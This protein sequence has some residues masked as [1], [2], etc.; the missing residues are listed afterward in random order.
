MVS[1]FEQLLIQDL[2]TKISG[3]HVIQIEAIT[4]NT[5]SVVNSDNF[6]LVANAIKSSCSKSAHNYVQG[7]T[8]GAPKSDLL[9]KAEILVSKGNDLIAFIIIKDTDGLV[10]FSE[11][12]SIKGKNKSS[13]LPNLLLTS[14]GSIQP[15]LEYS[16]LTNQGMDTVQTNF[17]GTV[18]CY[19]ITGSQYALGR[20]DLTFG[21]SIALMNTIP[22][23]VNVNT[24]APTIYNLMT[25]INSEL[26]IKEFRLFKINSNL[27]WHT[28]IMTDMTQLNFG[29]YNFSSGLGL[30]ISRNFSL[31]TGIELCNRS[32]VPWA[33]K[34]LGLNAFDRFYFG[35]GLG[36]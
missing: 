6:F 11:L 24:Q 30:Y 28:S 7:V 15:N 10:R 18:L 9:L 1:K 8:N 16:S 31:R 3:I 36:F 27:S 32:L 20:R 34:P 19:Q 26:L 4:A 22:I 23:N 21:Y 29:R 35:I 17:N 5:V 14:T 2:N 25:G 12:Y 13:P 33:D